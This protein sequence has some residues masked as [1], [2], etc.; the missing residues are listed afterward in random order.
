MLKCIQLIVK[1]LILYCY[2]YT[3]N[4]DTYNYQNIQSKMTAVH[5]VSTVREL[6]GTMEK[7]K[8]FDSNIDL[9]F[10]F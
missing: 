5:E 4:L 6:T 8:Y 7:S 9:A 2:Y 1:V 3:I 10:L